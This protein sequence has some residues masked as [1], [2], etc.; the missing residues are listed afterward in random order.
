VA[1]AA[2]SAPAVEI[3]PPPAASSAEP[4]GDAAMPRDSDA[5]KTPL[6]V[7]GKDDLIVVETDEA[8]HR[9]VVARVRFHRTV[10][11]QQPL[12][13][14]EGNDAEVLIDNPRGRAYV[15]HYSA[16]SS[17]AKIYAFDLDTGKQRWAT[18]VHGLEPVSHSKYFNHV[19]LQLEGGALTVLG[20]EA[21]GRYLEVFDPESGKMR[22]TRIL[23]A[24]DP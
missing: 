10:V 19:T 2:T 6:G 8:T 14:D 5:R 18:P 22:S 15:A 16:I 4:A 9:N 7:I 24:D 3:A 21:Q 23:P 11:W 17:G 20:D 12:P 1:P 13:E